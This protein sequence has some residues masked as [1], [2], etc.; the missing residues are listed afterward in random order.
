MAEPGRFPKRLI[1]VGDANTK[2]RLY[3]PQPGA[4]GR[5]AALSYC[6]GENGSVR[7]LISNLSSH[8]VALPEPLP[9]TIADAMAVTRALDI[10]Y[11]WIDSI[12]II[13]DSPTDWAVEA[14]QM[15]HVYANAYVTISADAAADASA[16]FLQAPSR[17]APPQHSIQVTPANDAPTPATTT[18]E[19]TSTIHVR[20]RGFLAEELPFHCWDTTL[21]IT[22]T[23]EP[24]QSCH[25]P[26]TSSSPS[27]P[28]PGGD[29]GG[30]RSRLSTRGWVFQERILSPRT[31][32]FSVHETA[33]E[34]RSL[35]DCEC[36]ATSARPRRTTSVVKHFLLLHNHASSNHASAAA[37]GDQDKKEPKPPHAM[38]SSSSSCNQ[39]I[40]APV[41]VSWRHN[42]VQAYTQLD[43]TVATDRLPA[44]A[45]LAEAA[46]WLRPAGDRYLAGLWKSSLVADLLWRVPAASPRQSRRLPTG[47]APSWSWGSVTGAVEYDAELDVALPNQDGQCGFQVQ[48]VRFRNGRPHTIAACCYAVPVRVLSHGTG[49]HAD[50]VPVNGPAG[51]RLLFTWDC[52]DD[53]LDRSHDIICLFV[54]FGMRSPR[55]GPFGILLGSHDLRSVDETTTRFK[56]LGFVEGYRQKGRLRRWDSG[57]W[58]SEVENRV[59]RSGG[60]SHRHTATPDS[61]G[62]N[63]GDSLPESRYSFKGVKYGSPRSRDGVVGYSTILSQKDRSFSDEETWIMLILTSRRR[64]IKIL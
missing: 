13:Q 60:T 16:G 49:C 35:C 54:V 21:G 20:A 48:D 55:Y 40:H 56:R 52:I 50:I 45:G 9:Q 26:I 44:L 18:N 39:A 38:P 51:A 34:C 30:G 23:P 11:L 61:D 29:K 6:W 12:C 62:L 47:Y 46:G 5:F 17:H 2:P 10:E 7:T 33:W 32:H 3:L 24:L 36:S 19:A 53:R 37:R 14:A 28:L 15:A 1:H 8:L 27:S 58:I 4:I 22:T 64:I 57:G 43:L 42:I 63:G 31:I 41:Q 59:F 25:F